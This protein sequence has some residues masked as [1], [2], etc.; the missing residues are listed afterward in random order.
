MLI[1]NASMGQSR[2]FGLSRRQAEQLLNEVAEN[3]PDIRLSEPEPVGDGS[4]PAHILAATRDLTPA[5]LP[6]G[7]TQVSFTLHAPHRGSR[8][9]LWDS[10]L[11]VTINARSGY[12]ALRWMV[13]DDTA[14]PVDPKIAE[15]LWLSNN[16]NPPLTDPSVFADPWLPSY[17]HPNSTM[18]VAQIRT[19]VEEFCL[20]RTGQRPACIDWTPGDWG[21]H[22]LDTPQL[23]RKT[24]GSGGCEDPW[25]ARPEP[26]HPSPAIG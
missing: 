24:V 26:E 18:P 14:V 19:A 3:R 7:G 9:E 4:V 20:T 22:R 16:P 25:S 11:D 23:V 10:S 5:T 6:Y 15:H 1:L 13:S 12:G 8:W 17:Y 21:G 2:Y